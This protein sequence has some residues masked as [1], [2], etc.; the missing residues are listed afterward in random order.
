MKKLVVVSSLYLFAMTIKVSAQQF[1]ARLSTV[2]GQSVYLVPNAVI[3]DDE[4]IVVSVTD[5]KTR[6][7][8]KKAANGEFRIV[9]LDSIG[10]RIVMNPTM[11]GSGEGKVPNCEPPNITVCYST[12]DKSVDVCLCRPPVISNGGNTPMIIAIRGRGPGGIRLLGKG[13]LK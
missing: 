4:T 1:I 2:E 11:D 6:F 12:P 8:L 7:E 9:L 5:E 10:S 13:G 3:K